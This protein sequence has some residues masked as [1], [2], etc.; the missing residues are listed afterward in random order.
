[1]KRRDGMVS[2]PGCSRKHKDALLPSCPLPQAR[3]PQ[4][5]AADTR[6]HTA[7][8]LPL[9]PHLHRLHNLVG[10]LLDEDER[11][12]EDVGCG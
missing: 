10:Q 2:S 5:Y 4:C 12:D 8:L 11:A 7:A 9:L 1:M 3:V 6:V